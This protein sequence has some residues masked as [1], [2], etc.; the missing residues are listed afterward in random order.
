MSDTEVNLTDGTVTLSNGVVLTIPQAFALSDAFQ[1]LGG[2]EHCHWH[3]ND[4]KCC[5]TVHGHDRAA[6]IGSDGGTTWYD[7]RGC[8]CSDDVQGQTT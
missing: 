8:A 1:E 7:H 3:L 2:R 4:C 6:V 5:L